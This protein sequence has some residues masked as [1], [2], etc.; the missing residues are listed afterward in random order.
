MPR[1]RSRDIAI[2]SR[3]SRQEST[4]PPMANAP[5]NG[6]RSAACSARLEVE[7]HL[8]SIA[9][10]SGSPTT[11]TITAP[12]ARGRPDRAGIVQLGAQLRSS[13]RRGSDPDHGALVRGQGSPIVAHDPD[14]HLGHG[15]AIRWPRPDAPEGTGGP[16]PSSGHSWLD[17]SQ[18]LRLPIGG[19]FKI[20]SRS[21][22]R[23]TMMR[24]AGPTPFFGSLP[25]LSRRD[26]G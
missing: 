19:V 10:C 9:K 24:F 16:R 18:S 5:R 4:P 8:R 15:A 6:R 25:L 14:D 23:R 3:V 21:C 17:C 22:K 1:S 13:L 11:Q 7:P 20:E 12:S 26:H 2:V